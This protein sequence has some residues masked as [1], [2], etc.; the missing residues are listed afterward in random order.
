MSMISQQMQVYSLGKV[1][2]TSKVHVATHDDRIHCNFNEVF[3][4]VSALMECRP[5]FTKL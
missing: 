5:H 2:E 1:P 4:A 3:S